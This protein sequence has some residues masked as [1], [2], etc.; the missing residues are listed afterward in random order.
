MNV[1]DP[2]STTVLRTVSTLQEAIHADVGL[3]TL[4][5]LT[6]DLAKVIIVDKCSIELSYQIIRVFVLL[7]KQTPSH[8]YHRRQHTT[9][10]F[11][12]FVIEIDSEPTLCMDKYV[13]LALCQYIAIVT[14]A[15]RGSSSSN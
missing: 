5:W 2:L 10:F 15:V 8:G 1:A 14:E 12:K 6:E 9:A 4:C 11:S 13:A 3:V 7:Y